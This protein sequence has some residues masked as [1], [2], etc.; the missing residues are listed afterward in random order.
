MFVIQT[1]RLITQQHYVRNDY[2]YETIKLLG[3]F[4]NDPA[5]GMLS[6]HSL[7]GKRIGKSTTVTVFENTE[8][9]KR[10]KLRTHGWDARV[11]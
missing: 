4:P 5:T 6:V 7:Y 11:S 9:G 1:D 8:T 2:I 10:R 3:V